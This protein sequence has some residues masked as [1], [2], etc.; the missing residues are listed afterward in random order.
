MFNSQN[1]IINQLSEKTIENFAL[2]KEIKQLKKAN[3]DLRMR[4]YNRMNESDSSD[5]SAESYVSEQSSDTDCNSDDSTFTTVTKKKRRSKK[6]LSRVTEYSTVTG[7]STSKKAKDVKPKLS[8]LGSSMVRN[9]GQ[10]ISTSLDERDTCVYSISGLSIQEATVQAKSVF[11]DHKDGDTTVLQVG[12]NDLPTYSKETLFNQYDKLIETVKV[13]APQAKHIVT[14]IP[15]RLEAGSA[16]INRKAD[17]LNS[18]LRSRCSSDSQLAFVDSNPEVLDVNYHQDLLHFSFKG[19]T[20]FA[21]YLAQYISHSANFFKPR[22]K[23]K[24]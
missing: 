16:A 6:N 2:Q 24:T 4:C 15:H 20:S 1:D 7:S 10:V 3:H 5:S 22:S 12:T 21:K 9:M 11:A 13:V 18:H 19:R 8:I 14:A 23:S 17:Q